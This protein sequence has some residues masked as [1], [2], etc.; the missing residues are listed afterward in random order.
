MKL[1]MLKTIDQADSFQSSLATHSRGR[2]K[3]VNKLGFGG[4]STVWLARDLQTMQR[5]L[6]ALKAVRADASSSRSAD[7]I[8]ELT[9]PRRLRAVLPSSVDI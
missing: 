3:V 7:N 4:S 8:P 2:Y 1:R 6:I 9:I 5:K